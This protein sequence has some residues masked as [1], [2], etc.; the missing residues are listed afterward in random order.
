MTIH[1]SIRRPSVAVRPSVRPSASVLP[2]LRPPIHPSLG[3][4]APAAALHPHRTPLEAVG[5]RLDRGDQVEL[6]EGGRD[7]VEWRDEGFCCH[8]SPPPHREVIGQSGTAP[9]SSDW[10]GVVVVGVQPADGVFC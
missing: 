9:G 3:S 4:G 1:P 2:S 6:G 7:G 5:R 10:R 8:R